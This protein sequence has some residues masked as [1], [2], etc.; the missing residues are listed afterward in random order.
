MV[1][2]MPYLLGAMG[3]PDIHYPNGT[4]IAPQIDIVST[5]PVR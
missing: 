2:P 4:E 5:R 3:L 1:K